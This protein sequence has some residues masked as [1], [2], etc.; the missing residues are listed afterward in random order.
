MLRL[1]KFC[2]RNTLSRNS[3]IFFAG[4]RLLFCM[5]VVKKD[6]FL[7]KC[8]AVGGKQMCHFFYRN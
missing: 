5:R 7:L 3:V 8:D 2:F 6:G 1:I 4:A